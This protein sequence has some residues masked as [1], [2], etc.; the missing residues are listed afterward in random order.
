MALNR[1][2]TQSGPAGDCRD[3]HAYQK[4]LNDMLNRLLLHI[5]IAGLLL[6]GVGELACA[7]DGFVIRG[8]ESVVDGWVSTAG[9]RSF[10][11]AK[12][13][14]HG[15]P[16]A[17]YQRGL[18][19]FDLQAIDPSRH[20][21]LKRAVLRL[22]AATVENKKSVPTVVS[23]SAISWNR[24]ATFLSPDSKTRWP[25]DRNRAENPDYAALEAGRSRQVITRAGTVE[26]DVTEILE[27]WLFQ[28][29]PNHGFLL[30]MG[31]PIFGRPD[32]GAWSIEFASSEAKEHG[33][34]LIIELEGAPP[35]PEAAEQRALALYPSAALP[36][37]KSPYAI[38]WYG[39]G[40]KELWSRFT[41]SNMS[42]YASIPEWLA[43]RGVLDMTW[44]E[45]GPIDWLPTDEAWEKYYLGI[46]ASNRA[47]CMHEWH[48]A[49]DTNDAKSAVRA[50]RLAERKHPRCYSAFYYQGQKEMADLAAKGELDLLI[51][52]GYTHVT[53]ELPLAG[54]TVGM[55]GIKQRI[56]IARRTGAIEKHVVML[57]H[58]APADKYHPGHELTPALLDDQIRQ[59]REYA[60]EMP[61]VG[62]Y[63]EGGRDLALE[64]DRLARKHFIDPAPDVEILAPAFEAR[65]S[66]TATPHVTIRAAAQP[67]GERKV[68][69]YRWFIDHRLVAETSTPHYVWDI[70]GESPGSHFVT[71]H[72]IDDGWN[73]AA[74]QILV[75]CE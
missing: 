66:K 37:V 63:Y 42:T 44:G 3:T 72:A 27:G 58:I 65:L 41:V 14:L 5:G 73:R 19:R 9:G 8:P 57:G 21:Q 30:T 25:A 35:T 50:A 60:P 70:R 33:P 53:K 54:F 16:W 13:Q 24:D 69:K 62:F 4:G 6:A 59:L 11:E 7:S 75:G 61:G 48:M 34:E 17:E 45:G 28:G 26:F 36:P 15:R 52:E 18:I 47:Y 31:S 22:H 32:A 68:E 2:G 40:D 46:A 10:D 39:A 12:L 49:S 23:A 67:K 29:Q 20:G 64:C 71:V 43:Q 38:V 74:A 51:Q 55:D 1:R 56:D